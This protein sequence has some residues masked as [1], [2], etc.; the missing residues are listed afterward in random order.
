LLES[1]YRENRTARPRQEISKKGQDSL[2][3]LKVPSQLLQDCCSI[4]NI[5]LSA[6]KKKL[7]RAHISSFTTHL[8][9]L[10]QKKSKFTQEE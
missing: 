10:E 5:A 4:A 6:S 9:A 2:N 7:E 3:V 1:K 8:K